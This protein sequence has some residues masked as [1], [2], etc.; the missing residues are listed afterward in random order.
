M[1]GLLWS[2][3]V[4]ATDIIRLTSGATSEG[5]GGIAGFSPSPQTAVMAN[6][7]LLSQMEDAKSLTL[8]ALAVD[9]TFTSKLGEASSADSGPGIL[10]EFGMKGRINDSAWSWGFAA[11]IQ[12]A[13]LADFTFTDPPGTAAVNYGPQQ[14]RSAWLIAKMGG[15]LS[16]DFGKG[17]SAGLT[18]GAAYNRNDLKAPYIFQSHPTLQGLKVLVDLSA[19]D[20][21][22]TSVLGM[23]YDATENVAID[24][25]YSF[26]TDFAASGSLQGNLGQ[27]GLGIQEDFHYKAHVDTAL[28]AVLL[29]G[30]SWQVSDRLT[31]G[32]QW[33]RVYWEDSFETLPIRLTR[34]SNSELNAFLG[35][36]SIVDSAPLNWRD[37]DSFHFGGEFQFADNRVLRLGFE[38]TESPVPGRTFTPL[39]GVIF[40]RAYSAGT[41]IRLGENLID[42]AYRF[43]T[44]DDVLVTESGLAGGEYTGTGQSLALHSLVF[45]LGF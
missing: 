8:T 2:Q 6:P 13:L 26:R 25:S 31:L 17:F 21:A 39:T 29:A 44:G 38:T 16:Y 15:A 30:V 3:Q 9:S 1:F 41:Q 40:D 28:P 22:L 4:S 33:D 34:G 24:V 27:L 20:V 36:D 42:I 35:E 12:S 7:A 37:Q 45:T 23:H 5:V 10:P 14:H 43:S 11:T 19:D 32:L 18:L